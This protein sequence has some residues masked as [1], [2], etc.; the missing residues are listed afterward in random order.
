M[1]VFAYKA[2]DA[3]ASV[4][5]GTIVADTPLQA[6]DDLRDRG[7]TIQDVVQ[8]TA[9]TELRW[10]HKR[11]SRR[12]AVKVV[13]FV[14]ELST[15][16]AVGM[17]LLEAIDTVARQQHGSFRGSL[18]ILRDQV[19]SGLSLADAMRQQP[20]VFDELCVNITEVGENAGTLES[21]LEQFAQFRERAQQLKGKVGSALLYPAIVLVTGI[22]VS[23]F[24]MT[25]VVPNLLE[26]L[27]GAGRPL[28]LVTQVVKAVSDFLV[29]RWWLLV[30]I[31]AGALVTGAAVLS[32]TPGRRL[33]HRWQLRVPLVGEMIRKQAIVR[34]AIVIST[35]MRSGVV[36]VRAVQIAQHSTRNLVLREALGRCEQ[37][38]H[39][40][41]DIAEALEDTGA[42]P[43]TVVQIFAIGQQ[44]GRLEEMLERLAA[45]YDVQVATTAGR[46]ASV[47]E[48]VLILLLAVIVGFIAF[49][50]ILPILEAGNV[51]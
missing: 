28:P 16:L 12:Y 24:L 51:L 10:W 39:A 26:S 22:G 43:L 1:A 23:I 11:S 5:S 29:Y 40:G 27:I 47:L 41:R 25:F 42:F 13:S 45:D 2:F 36:F 48:P 20:Q 44:S 14:R 21:V 46:L 9:G 7:L 4:V 38:V 8:R 49:A 19:A 17:P 35:L 15:L 6:R 31:V 50:T 18:L 34:I 30:A 37:A 32:S 3:D 33:W